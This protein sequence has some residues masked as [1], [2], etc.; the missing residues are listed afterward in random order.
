MN[1]TEEELL[2]LSKKIAHNY[3]LILAAFGLIY[4]GFLFY[5]QQLNN[6]R[7]IEDLKIRCSNIEKKTNE[8]EVVFAEIKQQLN[9]ISS[10]TK[11]IKRVI[12][13]KGLK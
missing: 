9:N 12:F 13:E 5:T 2:I 7:D 4:G 6:T 10:D 11:E 1:K 3:K 8:N